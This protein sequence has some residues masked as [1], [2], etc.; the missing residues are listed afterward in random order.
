LPSV[1]LVV[2][3]FLGIMTVAS[4]LSQKVRVP[5]TM[6]LVFLGIG[7]AAVSLSRI[8]G[9]DLIYDQLV[10]GGLFVGLV[11]P[12]LIFSALQ[13]VPRDEFRAVAR[14][15]F[16]LATAGVLISTLV[17]GLLLWQL[18]KLPLYASFLFAALISPTD[19]ATVLEI[20]R[21]VAVPSRLSTLMETE[22]AFNDA[23]AI[24]VFTILQAGASITGRL[25]LSAIGVFAYVFVGGMA[26]GFVIAVAARYLSRLTKDPLSE[27]ALT[28]ASVYGSYTLATALSV[29]GLVS[30]AIVGLYYGSSRPKTPSPVRL[31]WQ[32]A[33]FVANSVAFLFIGLSTDVLKLASSIVPIA[34][35][36]LAVLLARMASVYSI[37]GLSDRFSFRTPTKWKNVAMLGGMRGALSIALAASLPATVA[38]RD[39]IATMV[40]GVAFISIIGQG[41]I[42]SRYIARR[43]TEERKAGQESLDIRLEAALSRLQ[44]LHQL[45]I[46]GKVKGEEYFEQVESTREEIERL[47]V[48]MRNYSNNKNQEEGQYDKQVEEK[49]R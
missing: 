23:T 43:F 10:G 21:R 7:L 11:V 4:I 49:P 35:A 20:F 40:L 3:A 12:P 16:V 25:F 41:P 37:L 17:G 19:V 36:F 13:E 38:S 26:V 5:Y 22:A 1:E 14:P 48:D 15:A 47:L 32:I 44:D 31:F 45:K 42:L 27:I 2:A 9:V 46:A 34:I 33:A 28:M 30:V 8:L 29:S 18:A 6:V 39:V 24:V